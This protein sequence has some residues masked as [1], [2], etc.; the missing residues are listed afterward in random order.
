MFPDI[1]DG[2][3]V[4]AGWG[5]GYSPGMTSYG[6]TLLCE[7]A[8][9]DQLVA[10]AAH[11]D[12]A[13]FDFAAVSDHFYP[14]L[15]EQGH[16]PYAWSVLGAV[17]QAT[18]RMALMSFVTCPIRRY[19]PAVVAQK[20]ATM[21][22]LSGGRFT[23]GLG[24]GE[25]LNERVAGGWPAIAQRHQMF[26]EALGI[27][28]AL[29]D[30]A[31]LSFTGDYFD[32]GGAELFD[33]P[34]DG[35][36]MAVAVSGPESCALA[37]EYG[38]A[39]VATSPQS[40]LVRMF[41]ETGGEGGRRYGQVPVCYGPDEPECRALAREQFRWAA[42][43]WEV[44]SELPGPASFTTATRYVR[45]EDVAASVPCGPD[46]EQ[47]VAAVAAFRDAGFTDIALVQIG[48]DRQQEFLPWAAD[49]LLPALRELDSAGG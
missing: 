8:P 33:R 13:G 27:I 10:D 22:V 11:A 37:G 21:G 34:E 20:A 19:H 44:L 9:P 45:E 25:N 36:P 48:G 40:E 23:L 39:M 46:V 26:E 32:V 35:V 41:T 24:A 43:G 2:G 14:W 7:Q 1:A 5:D 17:A 12:E 47:H 4:R 3:G 31:S 49:K 15:P 42:L 28:R 38:D 18:R 6:Y 30:G 16:S 29:L